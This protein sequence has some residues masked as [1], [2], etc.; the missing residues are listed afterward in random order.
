MAT[1]LVAAP[2]TVSITESFTQNSTAKN[3][4]NTYTVNTITQDDV[5]T[6]TVPAASEISILDIAAAGTTIGPGKLL[7]TAIKYLRVTNKDD[8]NFF[9]LGFKTT[10]GNTVYFKVPAGAT[11]M[12]PVLEFDANI[13]GVA[14]VA[15]GYPTTIV[16]QA[17]TG[18]VQIEYRIFQT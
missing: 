12:L 11:F 1:T 2:E 8:T 5:R 4:I 3:S 7:S 18:N 13:T 9:R 10:D 15:Y 16:A 14:F 17:D 6:M